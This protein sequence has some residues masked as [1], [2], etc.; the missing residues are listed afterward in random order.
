MIR[1]VS[2]PGNLLLCGEYA[3]TRPSGCGAALAI[4]PVLKLSLTPA[5]FFSFTGNAGNRILNGGGMVRR[6]FEVLEKNFAAEK[7]SMRFPYTFHAD[8]A[9]FYASDGRKLG[10]GSSAALA[11]ALVTACLGLLGLLGGEDETRNRAR[12]AR[13]ALDAHRLYQDGGSGYDVYTSVYGGL[14]LFRQAAFAGDY[15][16]WEALPAGGLPS[17][18][19]LAHGKAPVLSKAAVQNFASWCAHDPARAA[20]FLRIS[21]KASLALT[22]AL[23][24]AARESRTG[25]A[26]A[27]LS[28]SFI[29]ALRAARRIGLY[30]GRALGRD[31]EPRCHEESL[32]LRLDRLRALGFEAKA[33]GAGS[34]LAFAFRASH[35]YTSP[36]ASP[37]LVLDFSEKIE[38]AHEGVQWR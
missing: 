5:P 25:T 23:H 37:D 38:I 17:P 14:G 6:V 3:I 11:V 28:P 33:G 27:S 34:E 35:P 36:D 30:I 7:I 4:S 32:G 10:Y 20:R 13:L 24:E 26:A 18:I 22:R 15:P 2:C 1:T 19:I 16:E 21:N 8:S 12:I 29:R 31:P 9:A